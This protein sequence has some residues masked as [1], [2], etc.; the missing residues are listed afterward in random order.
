MAEIM[1]EKEEEE[2]DETSMADS[3]EW[4]YRSNASNGFDDSM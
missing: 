4:K 2:D 1:K 3:G